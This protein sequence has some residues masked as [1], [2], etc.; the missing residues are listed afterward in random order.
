[1]PAANGKRYEVRDELVRGLVVRVSVTGAKVYCVNARS[2]GVRR[3][4]K[5]GTHPTISLA[6]A[7]EQ[8]RRVLRDVELGRFE[9]REQS[10]ATPTLGE[11]VPQ[12]I[13]LYSKPRNRDWKGKESVLKKFSSIFELPV[14]EVK[15]VDIVR[16]LDGMVM[17]GTQ[18]RA[19]RALAAIKKLFAWCVDRGTIEYSPIV[20]LKPPAKEV[21]RDRVLQNDELCRV[22][23]R[24]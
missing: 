8:A 5:I 21:A 17:R 1:L 15:R 3:R 18:V 22:L 23:E 7:R 10:T 14:D 2:H 12:F 16:V 9:E 20:G 6:D 13:E 11:I 4:I 24:S 19:N